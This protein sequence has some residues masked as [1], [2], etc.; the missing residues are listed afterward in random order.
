LKFQTLMDKRVAGSIELIKTL[1][2]ETLGK[3]R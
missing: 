2:Q 3:M 1:P